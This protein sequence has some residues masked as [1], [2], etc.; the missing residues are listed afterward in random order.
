MKAHLVH[1]MEYERGWG[2]RIE[3]RY[4]F[5]SEESAKDF[6]KAYD[7]KYNTSKTVPDWYMTQ[8]YIGE[9]GVDEEQYE[10]LKYKGTLVKM[11]KDS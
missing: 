8:Q 5:P 7:A 10:K 2:S 11:E 3:D 1:E 4:L 6:C 9:V